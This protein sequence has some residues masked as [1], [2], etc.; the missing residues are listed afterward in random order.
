M[1]EE[2]NFEKNDLSITAKISTHNDFIECTEY[3]QTPFSKSKTILNEKLHRELFSNITIRCSLTKEDEEK[4]LKAFEQPQ[5]I[6]QQIIEEFVEHQWPSRKK[7][8][9]QTLTCNPRE[10][11]FQYFI[12]K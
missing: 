1:K 8:L 7:I 4:I 11:Q 10:S 3:I 12:E 9:F 6:C 5:D 2:Y